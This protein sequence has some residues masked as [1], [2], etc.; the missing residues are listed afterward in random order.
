MVRLVMIFYE[1]HRHQRT[2]NLVELSEVNTLNHLNRTI[3][4]QTASVAINVEDVYPFQK[5][6]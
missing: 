5:L 4:I 1:A 6:I 2:S 3:I